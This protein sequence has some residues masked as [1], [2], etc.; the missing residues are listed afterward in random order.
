MNTFVYFVGRRWILLQKQIFSGFLAFQKEKN[1]NRKF[2]LIRCFSKL[3]KMLSFSY[4]S[5]TSIFIKNSKMNV[6]QINCHKHQDD[7][8]EE[9]CR[10]FQGAR[11]VIHT[12]DVVVGIS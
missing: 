11:V 9:F 7:S 5:L 3:C 4:N 6:I 10:G 1:I 8:E 2:N 12:T